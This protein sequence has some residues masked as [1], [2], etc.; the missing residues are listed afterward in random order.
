MGDV[1]DFR[2]FDDRQWGLIEKA[3][4]AHL[5]AA[6]SDDAVSWMFSETKRRVTEVLPSTRVSGSL[7]LAGLSSSSDV[8]RRVSEEMEKAFKPIV[9]GLVAQI[10]NAMIELHY[11]RAQSGSASVGA[12]P[13]AQI[14]EL[15]RG[16]KDENETPAS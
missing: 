13:T 2:A 7:S 16:G 5:G 10:A 14:L 8:A 4:R 1:V 6:A 11:A 9:S 12:L 3:I 15:I